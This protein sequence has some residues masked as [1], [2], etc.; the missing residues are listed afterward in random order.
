[1][2]ATERGLQV[3]PERAAVADRQC[4]RCRELFEGDPSLHGEAIAEWWA[5]SECRAVLFGAAR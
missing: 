3:D 4:G 5:C 1:M 2:W